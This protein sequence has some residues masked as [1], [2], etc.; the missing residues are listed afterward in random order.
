VVFVESPERPRAGAAVRVEGVLE[1]LPAAEAAARLR[2]AGGAAVAGG[3]ARL[4][5]DVQVVARRPSAVAVIE[6]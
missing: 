3:D 1:R 4:L 5:R 6:D 2:E